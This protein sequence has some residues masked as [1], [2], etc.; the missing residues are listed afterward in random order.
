MCMKIVFDS[1]PPLSHPVRTFFVLFKEAAKKV[2]FLVVLAGL[3]V[4]S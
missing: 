2:I 3:G 4:K 1:P